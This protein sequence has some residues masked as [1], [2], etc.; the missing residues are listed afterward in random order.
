M[1]GGEDDIAKVVWKIMAYVF[2]AKT[3]TGVTVATV[4]KTAKITTAIVKINNV[5]KS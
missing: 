1:A 2:I 5:S 3:N 4:K